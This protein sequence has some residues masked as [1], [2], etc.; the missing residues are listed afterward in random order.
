MDL[1][2]YLMNGCSKYV[3]DYFYCGVT[4]NFR[5]YDWN[6]FRYLVVTC[7]NLLDTL[8]YVLHFVLVP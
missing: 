3:F 2:G 4:E 1:V 7:K 8:T 6:I 5:V